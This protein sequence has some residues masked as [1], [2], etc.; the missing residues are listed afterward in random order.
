MVGRTGLLWTMPMV[1]GLTM[2][3]SLYPLDPELP[4]QDGLPGLCPALCPPSPH[5][6]AAACVQG[7]T[8][9]WGPA[10][11]QLLTYP[12]PYTCP[13]FP[14]SAKCGQPGSSG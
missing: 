2:A 14:C 8:S 11:L 12:G 7:I 10:E 4:Q 5:T 13:A 6:D 9:P 1:T 3:S